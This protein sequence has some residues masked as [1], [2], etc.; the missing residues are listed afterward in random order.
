MSFF[1]GQPHS[2]FYFIAPLLLL[3]YTFFAACPFINITL[4]SHSYDA[5][6][7]MCANIRIAISIWRNYRKKEK[8]NKK[9]VFST[10]FVKQGDT[11]KFIEES[12]TGPVS[13]MIWMLKH[14]GK[15]VPTELPYVS[16]TYILRF[17]PQLFVLLNSCRHP[18]IERRKRNR[19]IDRNTS[20]DRK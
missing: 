19:I 6:M 16:K 9:I 18:N 1:L 10:Y 7:Q 4:S 12:N 2:L 13:S 17:S 14:M 5:I 15:S 3:L 8:E 20:S 11:L